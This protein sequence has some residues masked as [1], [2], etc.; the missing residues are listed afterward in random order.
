MIEHKITDNPKEQALLTL[1]PDHAVYAIVLDAS[2]FFEEEEK[3]AE[4]MA[5]KF[6]AVGLKV[7]VY[8]LQKQ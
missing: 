8:N 4:T 3:G 5:N 6:S 7:K 2:V 1:A